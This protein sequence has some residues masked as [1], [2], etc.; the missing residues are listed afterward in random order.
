MK[1]PLVYMGMAFLGVMACSVLGIWA[2]PLLAL[3]IA[4]FYV[5]LEKQDIGHRA[6]LIILGLS[7]VFAVHTLVL[8]GMYA[9]EQETF[10]AGQEASGHGV[11]WGIK[12]GPQGFTYT[13]KPWWQDG[14]KK[15]SFAL[16]VQGDKKLDIG[17]TVGFSGQVVQSLKGYNEGAFD[18]GKH[19]RQKQIIG[20]VRG[21]VT[22]E[23][24]GMAYGL[25]RCLYKARLEHYKSLRAL[26]PKRH[27]DVVANLL[28]GIDGV[29]D[30]DRHLFQATGTVHILAISGL[31]VTLIA[32][33]LMGLMK[34]LHIGQR[35]GAAL[36]MVLVVL[37]CLYTGAHLS[38]VRATVMMLLYLGHRMVYRQYDKHVAIALA[39]IIMVWLNPF[40]VTSPGFVLS[41]AAVASIFYVAP[42]LKIGPFREQGFFRDMVRILLAVQLGIGPIL[43]Y[44]FYRIPLYSFLGNMLLVPVLSLI[45]FSASV[46][47]VLS[48]VSTAL[49]KFGMGMAFWLTE[50][51]FRVVSIVES[52]PGAY[53]TLGQPSLISLVFYYGAVTALVLKHRRK[54]LV[55]VALLVMV[56]YGQSQWMRPDLQVDMMD[57]G[58]GDAI[59]V[60]SQGEVLLIDGGGQGGKSGDNVGRQVL[61]PFMYKNGIHKIDTVI[62]SHF[63][64]DHMYGII[65]LIEEA[66]PIGRILVSEPYATSDNKWWQTLKAKALEKSVALY[67][68]KAGDSIVRRDLTIQVLYPTE[69]FQ[70]K[71]NNRLSSVLLL[72]YGDFDMLLT[73]DM[74]AEDERV[75]L[76]MGHPGIRN[77]D[78]L[79]VGHH[80]SKTSSTEEFLAQV[81]PALSLVSVGRNNHYNHPAPSVVR[82]LVKYS[83]YVRM[84][85]DQGQI[86]VIYHK[87]QLSV[88]SYVERNY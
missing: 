42:G 87:G 34:G 20:L 73:G 84:T 41:F 64:F 56:L 70:A 78:V 83:D 28:M 46:G 63:D 85:K 65:E 62:I 10:M 23:N 19:Y 43:L 6:G 69:N 3:A 55:C 24:R 22:K 61:L 31:H 67:Y 77:V 72:T 21:Q 11:I 45:I 58:N 88:S 54:A 9:K 18:L 38:T 68:I 35:K 2:M 71:D 76:T 79:K 48:Y 44:F 1:R 39:F 16:R 7:V 40:Q 14:G 51:M 49:A 82:R 32:G 33:M 8:F 17:E 30:R 26:M 29:S 80:G 74:V 53:L 52:L 13:L 75:L 37:Y 15:S 25:R 50:Y 4:G 27:R 5:H 59:F 36:T 66:V 12:E 60:R 57:V 81:S 47:I 86:T